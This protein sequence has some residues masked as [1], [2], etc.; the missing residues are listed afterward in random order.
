MLLEISQGSSWSTYMAE[1]IK[2][3]YSIQTILSMS[4]A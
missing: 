4:L 3:P 2:I 1:N